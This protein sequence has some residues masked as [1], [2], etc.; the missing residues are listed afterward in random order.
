MRAITSCALLAVVGCLQEH[1]VS[2][3]DRLCPVGTICIDGTCTFA[4]APATCPA[5]GPPVF[6]QET[7]QQV[8]FPSCPQSPKR[9]E[10]AVAT[11]TSRVMLSCDGQIYE[12]ELGRDVA[13]SPGITRDDPTD[14]LGAPHPTPEGDRVIVKHVCCGDLGTTYFNVYA[15]SSDGSW[16]N[17]G[18]PTGLPQFVVE[19]STPTR[20]DPRR[21]MAR[22]FELYEL[23]STNDLDWQQVGMPYAS[24]EL[25]PGLPL[26]AQ[27]SPD[28]L[29]LV[30]V[31]TWTP[32][33]F[34]YTSRPDLSSRFP[35]ATMLTSPPLLVDN[36]VASPFLSADCGRLYFEA[37]DTE[38][39]LE[40]AR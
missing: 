18:P 35:P 19:I 5:S 30:I 14:I 7:L 10:L 34:W 22:T 21:V 9:K 17:L 36:G 12:G 6:S 13:L 11:D 33:G 23:E 20:G 32:D 37:L 29:R 15:R 40:Q 8:I 27:L 39:Y 3:G 16:T 1:V 26:Q 31:S 28:G 25:A 24:G 38:F 2:C 4:A